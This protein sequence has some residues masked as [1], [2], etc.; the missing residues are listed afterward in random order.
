MM[1]KKN[2]ILYK[3]DLLVISLETLNVHFTKNHKTF[4]FNNLR[5]TLKKS[6]LSNIEQLVK[7]IKYIK[8]ITRRYLLHEIADNILKNYL[9]HKKEIL[10]NKYCQKIYKTN[11]IKKQYYKNYKLLHSKSKIDVNN[12]NFINLYLISNLISK[13]GTDILI[14]YLLD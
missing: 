5:N 3:I 1:I 8:F 13:N 9:L 14:R 10:M 2:S 11:N 4:K 12:I 7:M 6:K